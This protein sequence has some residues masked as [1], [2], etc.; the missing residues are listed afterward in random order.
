LSSGYPKAAVGIIVLQVF[1][2]PVHIQEHCGVVDK[3]LPEHNNIVDYQRQVVTPFAE[4]QCLFSLNVG[5][6]ERSVV[7]DMRGE[8]YEGGQ[9]MQAATP[10]ET[11][12]AVELPMN[13]KPQ[14][15]QTHCVHRNGYKQ[16]NEIII[17]LQI[18]CETCQIYRH[19][20]RNNDN[21]RP[22]CASFHP[23]GGSQSNKHYHKKKYACGVYNN[24]RRIGEHYLIFLRC[25]GS[26][27]SGERG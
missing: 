22:A 1:F 4:Q 7:Y 24:E 18:V 23:G 5:G 19:G 15:R 27:N 21:R 6:R 12:C 16:R 25:K 10:A 2:S 3:K 26:E 8:R 11:E 13:K 14:G 17:R 9:E 20:G